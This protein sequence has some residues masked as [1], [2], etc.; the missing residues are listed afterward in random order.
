MDSRVF[1]PRVVAAALFV[2]FATPGVVLHRDYGVP[3]D[4]PTQREY[5]SL[6]TQYVFRGDDRLFTDPIRHYGPAHEMVLFAAEAVVAARDGPEIWS[7]RHLVNFLV[8]AAGCVAVYLLGLAGTGRHA[9]GLV[10]SLALVLSPR[11]FAD[12][13]YNSK[14]VPFLAAF[15]IAMYTLLRFVDRPR[16]STVVAHTLASA[17]LVAIRAPG[18]IVPALTVACA[19]YWSLRTP[20]APSRGR[21]LGWLAAYVGMTAALTVALW[22]TLWREPASSFWLA[23]QTMSRFPWPHDVLYAG[24]FLP[25]TDLPWHYAPVWI[26]ITT[27][28]LYL[29]AF[30]LGLPAILRTV[31]RELTGPAELRGVYSALLLVWLAGPLAAA[32][33]FGTVLYDGWRQLFFVYP[34]LL[35][36]AAEGAVNAADALRRRWDRVPVRMIA[37][38]AAVYAV[39]G[40]GGIVRFMVGAHPHQYVYFNMLVGGL[41]GARFAYEMDYWGLSYRRGLEAIVRLDDAPFVPV[42]VADPPGEWYGPILPS[43]DRQRV[44]FVEAPEQAKY[45]LGAYRWRQA[46][47]PY[48]RM[49]HREQVDGVPIL[50]VALIDPD[51][52]MTAESLPPVAAAR[53]GNEAVLAGVADADLHATVH[54]AIVEALMSFVQ[55][56]ER[57]DVELSDAPVAALRTGQIERL[58]IRLRDADVGDFRRRREGVPVE[59]LDLTLAN[60]T[61]D[62][63]RLLNGEFRLARVGRVTVHDLVVDVEAVNGAL[64]RGRGAQQRLSL[65]TEGGAVRVE[66]RGSPGMEATIRLRIGP[67]PWRAESDNLFFEL[68]GVRLAGW[69]VPIAGLLQMLAGRAFSPVLGPGAFEPRLVLGTLALDG[70]QIRLG[71]R[72]DP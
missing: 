27:P 61:L 18:I 19:A 10:A 42:A 59:R 15:A 56:A 26:A 6:V 16:A 31:A 14:D 40:L 17:W 60:V 39:V 36:I 49:V 68:T 2:A 58:D 1:S 21:R 69:R 46:E 41:P 11:L 7:A 65:H 52:V 62:L 28:L 32:I 4:E 63:S 30:G 5:A 12:A 66:R 45:F 57:V 44:V 34:A 25:A 22:P 67:D 20:A 53:A 70:Q 71:T 9:V 33:L 50:S 48:G 13:F 29:A 64:R 24:R 8:F 38:A 55:R 35:L 47:Y 37:A 51:L 3:W 23:L 72:V 54:R 43:R